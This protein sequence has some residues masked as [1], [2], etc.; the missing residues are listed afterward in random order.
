MSAESYYPVRC[1]SKRQNPVTPPPLPLSLVW[2][3]NLPQEAVEGQAISVLWTSSQFD[4]EEEGQ[5]KIQ[6]RSD[7]KFTGST[8]PL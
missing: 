8:L 6:R 5:A 1:N 2:Y 7:I 3:Q 4:E